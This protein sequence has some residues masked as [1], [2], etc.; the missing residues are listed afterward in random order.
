M[1]ATVIPVRSVSVRELSS[2]VSRITPA[3]AS[4]ARRTSSADGAA[5]REVEAG[6]APKRHHRVH[7]DLRPARQGSH[8]DGHP[9][10]R[11]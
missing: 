9:G 6:S 8:A 7:L 1:S 11:A 10:R 4:A 2:G 3:P 5:G